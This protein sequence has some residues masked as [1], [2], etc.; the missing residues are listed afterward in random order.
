[1]RSARLRMPADHRKRSSSHIPTTV[2]RKST[3][4]ANSRL[5]NRHWTG[6]AARAASWRDRL[7]LPRWHRTVPSPRRY[8]R[9]QGEQPGCWIV[10]KQERSPAKE[11]EER[12]AMHEPSM[13]PR[14]AAKYT[15]QPYSTRCTTLPPTI[16]ATTFPVN[17]QPSNGVLCDSERDLAASKVQRFLG[18]KMV[19]SAKLPR[20]SDPRPWR[21]KTL[22]G[23]AVK[24]STIRVSGIL[25]SR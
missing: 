25:C 21:S 18:S 19:T 24:S 5:Q 9:E 1:M 7:R 2:V 14:L 22:A 11:R 8:P 13:P 17:C 20:A 4:E 6:R 16:V 3:E 23:P 15:P 12:I 10:R